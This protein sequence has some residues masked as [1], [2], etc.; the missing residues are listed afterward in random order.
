MRLLLTGATGFVGRN[1][2]LQA[3]SRYET[4]GVPVRSAEKLRHQLAAEGHDPCPPNLQILSADPA[5]WQDF[6]PDHAVLSAGILF[7]RSRE[8]YFSTNVDWTLQGVR[9]LPATCQTVVI[10]S[11]SAGGPTPE[12]R[13]ARTE[14]DPDRPLTWYGDSKVALEEALRAE[15]PHHALTILRPPMILGPRDT[16]TLPLF[17]MAGNSL[18][19]KPG[20]QAKTYSFLAVEDL[21]DAIIT[22]LNLSAPLP[23]QNY[24]LSAPQTVTDSELIAAVAACRQIRGLTL[25]IPQPAMKLLSLLVDTIPALRAQLPSLTRDRAKEIW[26][27]RWVCDGSRFSSLT[28]WYPQKKLLETLHATHDHFQREGLL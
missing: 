17:R 1:L 20:L 23:P 21:V 7:A 5:T 24:Y 13:P 27:S 26:P 2:L 10:S 4:V 14:S 15:F 6:R 8:E 18:R 22:V 12:A 19:L 25:P 16:A 11:L 3:L 28:G 9:A